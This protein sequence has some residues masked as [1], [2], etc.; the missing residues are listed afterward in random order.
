MKARKKSDLPVKD[1]ATCGRPFAWRA[2]WRRDW[3]QVRH[4]SERCRRARQG[5]RN[6]G[7]VRP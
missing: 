7:E 2:K 1:C 5:H 3:D 6:E 4:C